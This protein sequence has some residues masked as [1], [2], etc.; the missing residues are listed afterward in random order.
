MAL[1]NTN[2]LFKR[3]LLKFKPAL[4]FPLLCTV[5]SALLDREGLYAIAFQQNRMYQEGQR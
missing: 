2:L 3:Y 1:T 4:S 5:R